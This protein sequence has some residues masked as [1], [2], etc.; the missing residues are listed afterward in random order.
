MEFTPTYCVE[1]KKANY[2][3]WYLWAHGPK[4]DLRTFK[5]EEKAKK[6]AAQFFFSPAKY[7]VIEYLRVRSK[8]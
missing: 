7:R 6:E 4:G 2:E 1:F 8:K 3:Y 5:T